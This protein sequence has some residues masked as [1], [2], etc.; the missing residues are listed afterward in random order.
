MSEAGRFIRESWKV[1]NNLNESEGLEL[2]E[3]KVHS[4]DGGDETDPLTKE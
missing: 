2:G 3:L 1:R 4:P